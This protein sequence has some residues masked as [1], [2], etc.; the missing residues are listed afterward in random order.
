MDYGEVAVATM[1]WARDAAEE[2]LLRESL[3]LLAGLGV[4][5]FVTDGGSGGPL[6]DFLRAVPHFRVFEAGAP[7]AWP[8]ARTSIRAAA[9]ADARFIL[10]AEPD[11]RDFFRRGLREFI[12]EAPADDG[13]GV[14]LASRSAE[15]FATFPEFQRQTE[16]ADNRCCAEVLGVEADFTYG[17]FLLNRALVPHLGGAADDL[18]WGWRPHAFGTARRLGYRVCRVEGHLPCPPEQREDDAAERLYRIRQ[19]GQN[20]RGLV[21][22]LATPLEDVDG[23]RGEER[24]HGE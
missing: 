4:P 12:S 5:V 20:I 14:V 16:T 21:G 13:V 17:P 18:G 15:S 7:G 2:R 10:Y 8:Q 19:L 11:K 1:T 6:L 9:D 3:H 23:A 24:E 22:S